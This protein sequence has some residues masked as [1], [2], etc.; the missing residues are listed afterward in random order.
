MFHEMFAC[1][2]IDTEGPA[3]RIENI[4]CELPHGCPADLAPLTDACSHA[5]QNTTPSVGQQKQVIQSA[6]V[7]DE[8][9]AQSTVVNRP[10]PMPPISKPPPVAQSVSQDAL[11]VYAPI[12]LTQWPIGNLPLL[13]GSSYNFQH[14]DSELKD[15]ADCI[16][17][18]CDLP[19]C[20]DWLGI[21]SSLAV[22]SFQSEKTGRT[23]PLQ[24]HER[25]HVSQA[26]QTF[27]MPAVSPLGLIATQ[28]MDHQGNSGP[29]CDFPTPTPTDTLLELTSDKFTVSPGSCVQYPIVQPSVQLEF[30]LPEWN[31][32]MSCTSSLLAQSALPKQAGITGKPMVP[33]HGIGAEPA[34]PDTCVA[35]PGTCES[36]L[37]RDVH[38]VQHVT[39]AAAPPVSIADER[40]ATHGPSAAAGAQPMPELADS[41]SPAVLL[42]AHCNGSQSTPEQGTGH[43]G[44]Y[45]PMHWLFS[46]LQQSDVRGLQISPGALMPPGQA[47]FGQLHEQASCSWVNPAE[48]CFQVC[49]ATYHV[50]QMRSGDRCRLGFL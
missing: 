5:K 3:S 35:T 48:T 11:L 34:A 24:G 12:D 40:H 41:G 18:P 7:A 28:S 16:P 23:C 19:D 2:Q 30:S 38:V 39:A 14:C 26:P 9:T 29:A 36:V 6:N 8:A 45:E 15:A 49:S 4:L 17:P 50:M 44:I 47:G 27:P 1:V 43:R 10:V 22:P 42:G 21:D 32:G 13:Q 46:P 31:A 25:F 20:D 33:M 37:Y